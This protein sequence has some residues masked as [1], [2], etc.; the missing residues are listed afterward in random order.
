MCLFWLYLLLSSFHILFSLDLVSH[1]FRMVHLTYYYIYIYFNKDYKVWVEMWCV[2][3]WVVGFSF[4]TLFMGES[5]DSCCFLVTLL[6]LLLS[7][8]LFC[9]LALLDSSTFCF[10]HRFS[11]YMIFSALHGTSSSSHFINYPW[12]LTLKLEFFY[13]GKKMTKQVSNVIFV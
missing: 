12:S 10:T 13:I 8:S 3:S 9:L 6:C 7:S 5:L 11:V 4:L 2:V 1:Y